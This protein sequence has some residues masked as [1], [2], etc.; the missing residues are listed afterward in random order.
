M[1]E[2]S[3]SS[4]CETLSHQIRNRRLADWRSQRRTST[5]LAV[6]MAALSACSAFSG[7]SSLASA[8]QLND[9]AVITN[10]SPAVESKTA[11][12]RAAASREP[13]KQ[14]ISFSKF[15]GNGSETSS[16]RLFDSVD[17]TA[18]GIDFLHQSSTKPGSL[19]ANTVGCGVCLGDY[20]GDGRCDVFICD[21]S[22]GGELYRNLGEFRFENV[23]QQAGIAAPGVWSTGATF[24]DVEGDG[25]LDLYVCSFD[26]PNRLYIHQGDGSFREQAKEFGLDYRGSSTAMTFADYDADGDL[27][28]YLVTNYLPPRIDLSYRLE[29]DERG[30]PRVPRAYREYHDTIAMP[31]REYGVVEAG[32]YDH[33]Y[34]NEGNGVFR[35]VTEASGLLANFKGLAA[36]WW[37]FNEDNR[38]DLYVANDFYG[39]DHLFR[40]LG[41]GKFADVTRLSLPHTPWF[42]M[43][44]DLGDINNDGLI[45]FVASDMA[46]SSHYREKM[47]T[48]DMED[49]AWFLETAEPRQYMRNAVY[50]NSGVERMI[51]VGYLAGLTSTDWTWSIKLHDFDQDGRLDIFVTNG[52]NRDWENSDLHHEGL[53]RGPANSPA[54][55][56]FWQE[57]PRLDES[58][59]AFWNR[60]EL[61]FDD[62][63]V[64][65][66]LDFKGVS[67]G[68]AA[69]DLD[70]DGDLDLVVN[71]MDDRPG[72][73]RNAR[74]TGA[75][76]RVR[77]KGSRE[78]PWAVG[79]TVRI[80]TADGPQVRYLTPARGFM[81]GD[82]ATVHFGL[83]TTERIDRLTVRWPSGRE[84]EFRDLE[85]NGLYTISEGDGDIKPVAP[86]A[87]T[88]FVAS[89]RFTGG[90]H[91]EAE[92]NDF[93]AQPLLPRRLSRLGPG[94][95]VGDVDG[96]H[97]DDIFLSGAR[98]MA[99]KLLNQDAKGQFAV[100]EL[101]PPWAD[102]SDAECLGAAFV[103]A[104][105]DGDLD[106]YVAHGGVESGADDKLLADALYMNDG[107]GRFTRA[108]VGATP[109]DRQSGGCVAAADYD[110]DGDVDLFVGGRCVP[111]AYPTLPPNRLLRNDEGKF[112][113]ADDAATAAIREPG[114]ATAAVWSDAN[115][116]GWIDLLI[117]H[118]WGPIRVLLNHEGRFEDA[119]EA[120]KL[121]SLTGWWNGITTADI[122]DDGDVDYVATN[123]GVNSRYQPSE[124]QPARL[125]YADW[126]G[127][128]RPAP[129]EATT[130][131]GGDLLPVRGKRA[132]E[133][134]V[135][136]VAEKCPTYDA[137]ARTT[138]QE[139]LGAEALEDSL[140]FAATTLE[141][142]VLLND[143]QAHFKFLPLP[144]LAQAAPAFGVAAFDADAD[145]RCDLFLAQN[146]R[147]VQRE[148]G[149]MDG[150]VGLLL[151]GAGD[152]TFR[153]VLPRQSGL[154]VPDEGRA[155]AVA[156][157][158]LD[159]RPDLVV[160]VNNGPVLAFENQAT[161]EARHVAIR[162]RGLAGNPQAIG[163]R[164]TVRL[165]GGGR[166]HLE[167]SGGG[168]YLTHGTNE[169]FLALPTGVEIEAID[170]RWPN[171]TTT[172]T[173]PEPESTDDT[174]IE[175]DAKS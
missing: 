15:V 58:N 73:Y 145:G 12:E 98:G 54:Y 134:A 4:A 136:A 119:T 42:S 111:G 64:D 34:Q 72:L 2:F 126:E 129:I 83:G 35:D 159:R 69:G 92:F 8:S 67:Y 41:E 135:T 156:D 91:R 141:S 84:D 43:G 108:D 53:K 79:A 44:C 78:N 77:L 131:A 114:M 115:G 96:D 14:R 140:S 71:N 166:R 21:S 6:A 76:V 57:Q 17:P 150:G 37:D 56:S 45:D 85:V 139:L 124:K 18:A 168:C 82:D 46:G 49:D 153:P 39:P 137:Y 155:V 107:K 113:E 152:G 48:G 101:F 93:A 142:G 154:V 60:G 47:T 51:E 132:L 105:S 68:A 171:G 170:V 151:K 162:L 116:D 59:F 99:C 40:N 104:D 172:T 16:G 95:A 158:N 65:W 22:N 90:D 1:D 29:L 11:A 63:S 123:F 175:I 110:R 122:D 7:G 157:L 164:L 173:K 31:D 169:R 52:M 9:G 87:S 33:L 86:V 174:L 30:I 74:P 28:G 165:S 167:F 55:D 97:R 103:D 160:G 89:E 80:E 5:I 161:A 13:A 94:L 70:A 23:T 88:W 27:D 138:L 102:D 143:G 106:V 3:T 25:D 127:L 147:G 128:D 144:R 36:T 130:N 120:S 50:L 163:A 100:D 146:F 62:V 118:E 66:G 149:D 10:D 20:D 32:Q 109:A 26:S 81:S 117:A 61:K 148:A 112:V 125:F 24:V 121:A 19:R 38:P 75:S 133:Q